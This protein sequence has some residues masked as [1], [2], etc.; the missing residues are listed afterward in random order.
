MRCVRSEVRDVCCSWGPALQSLERSS[1]LNSTSLKVQ[2][3]NGTSLAPT[4]GEQATARR[5]AATMADLAAPP[6][7]LCSPHS[8]HQKT[9]NGT[10]ACQHAS[11]G[12]RS[13][14]LCHHLW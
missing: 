6:L 11:E 8:S 2:P 10:S 14:A 9:A 1:S 7:R 4:A 12:L 5:S 13:R 3:P